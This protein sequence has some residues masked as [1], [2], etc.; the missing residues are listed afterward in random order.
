MI[1]LVLYRVPI[2]V[3]TGNSI[4]PNDTPRVWVNRMGWVDLI[5]TAVTSWLPFI[6]WPGNHPNASFNRWKT[7]FSVGFDAVRMVCLQQQL[8][9]RGPAADRSPG[10]APFLLA[11]RGPARRRQSTITDIIIVT[12]GP[13]RSAPASASAAPDVAAPTATGTGCGRGG[14]RRSGSQ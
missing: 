12:V 13:I 7:Y 6:A 2:Q 14:C 4:D 1:P 5:G 11:P 9:A 10:G 8:A 3:A